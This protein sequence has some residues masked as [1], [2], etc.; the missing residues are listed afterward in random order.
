MSS[1]E[2]FRRGVISQR[3]ARHA[4]AQR[5]QQTKPKRV[6]TKGECPHCGQYFI[7][8]LHLHVLKKHGVK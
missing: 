7:R 8:G 1:I 6:G 3:I 2:F 4:V 5:E